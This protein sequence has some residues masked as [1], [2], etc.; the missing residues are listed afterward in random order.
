MNIF[1]GLDEERYAVSVRS[2]REDVVHDLIHIP[3]VHTIEEYN[4]LQPDPS[5]NWRIR[6]AS[7]G[8]VVTLTLDYTKMATKVVFWN[9][10]GWRGWEPDFTVFVNLRMSSDIEFIYKTA[11]EIYYHR[12]I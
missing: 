12:S 4:L 6:Q 11:C 1:I 5:V 10:R 2:A 8:V 3:G 9:L 7:N